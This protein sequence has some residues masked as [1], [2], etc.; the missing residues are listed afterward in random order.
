[1]L[2]FDVAKADV[3]EADWHRTWQ[4]V[5]TLLNAKFSFCSFKA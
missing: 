1:M 5:D 3:V 2:G 4:N